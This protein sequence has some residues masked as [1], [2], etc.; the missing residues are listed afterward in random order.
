MEFDLKKYLGKW[1]EIARIKNDFEPNLRKVTAQYSFKNDGTIQ[2]INS[3]YIGNK[4]STIEGIARKTED[5]N[6]LKV[7]FFPDTESYYKILYIDKN[8]EYALV[9]GSS[10]ML[11]WILSRTPKLEK[12]I[13]D[14]LIGIAKEIGYNTDKVIFTEQ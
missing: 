2:V 11:L 14:K 9:G 8:Y 5:N 4:L 13:L 7:S 6:I 3:G 10:N 1:Y 12:S